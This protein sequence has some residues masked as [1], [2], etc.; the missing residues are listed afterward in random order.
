[1]SDDDTKKWSVAAARERLAALS[2]SLPTSIDHAGISLKAKIPYKVLSFREALIWRTEEVARCAC[3]LLDRD[4]LASAIILTRATTENAAAIW[5]LFELIKKQVEVG[6]D[7]DLDERVMRLLMG[8]RNN[9]QLPSAVQVLTMLD[10][11]N[12]VI[13]GIRPSYDALSEY[14]HPNWSGVSS[15]FSRI[16]REEI[17]TSFGRNPRGSEGPKRMALAALIGSLEIFTHAYD[18]LSDLMPDF[19][20]ACEAELGEPSADPS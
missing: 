5:Y 17:F 20:R 1:M 2:S 16:H 6:I 3:D 19:I 11:A 8:S 10:R 15:L 7:A 18:S 4:D 9:D 14:A 12:K 13:N